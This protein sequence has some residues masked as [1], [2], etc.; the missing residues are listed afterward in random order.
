MNAKK[1]AAS[2]PAPVEDCTPAPVCNA[3]D[4][5]KAPKKRGLCD[6]HWATLRG[7]ADPKKG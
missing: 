3:P 4:C 6:P 5:T 1:T 7:L 2:K